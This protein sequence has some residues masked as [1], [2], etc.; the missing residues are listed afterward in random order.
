[1]PLDGFA[2]QRIKSSVARRLCVRIE[3]LKAS[4]TL[5]V[6]ALNIVKIRRIQN[7]FF[8]RSQFNVFHFVFGGVGPVR[9][10]QLRGP[11][12]GRDYIQM[13]VT[14]LL[15]AKTM[16]PSAANFNDSLANGGSESF[17]SLPLCH[18]SCASADA[19]SASQMAHGCARTGITGR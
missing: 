11:T 3:T 6:P 13:V 18:S 5:N 19:A 4:G 12:A 2:Q 17:I 15:G 7:I 8:V 1:M 16:R 14:I 10:Q 9:R